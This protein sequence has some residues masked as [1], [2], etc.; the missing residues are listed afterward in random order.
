MAAERLPQRPV[1]SSPRR[2][3]L[4]AFIAP[5]LVWNLSAAVPFILAPAT[6]APAFELAGVAGAVMVR[7]MGILFLMWN[8][9]HTVALRDPERYRICV[10]VALMQQVIG[11]A[12]E[13]FM[14]LT[15]PPG[16]AALLATGLRFIAFDS[17]GLVL[18]GLTQSILLFSARHHE[19]Q[20]LP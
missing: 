3:L 12:G 2:W 15:L 16:H 10:T 1:L 11:L 14:A 17:A 19:Q 20:L 6:Y 4:R 9:P 5:V 8:V 18:L 13:L 7:G